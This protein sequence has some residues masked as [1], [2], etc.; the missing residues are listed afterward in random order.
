MGRDYGGWTEVE[1]F[2]SLPAGLI[3][4]LEAELGVETASLR[5]FEAPAGGRILL[6]TEDARRNLPASRL[7]LSSAQPLEGASLL[8]LAGIGDAAGHDRALASLLPE[9]TA[10]TRPV[11]VATERSLPE[12]G[13][14]ASAYEAERVGALH[15]GS[16]HG[17]C[18]VYRVARRAAAAVSPLA[19]KRPEHPDS[20]ARRGEW[21]S[22]RR[23]EPPE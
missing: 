12:S 15:A 6:L 2:S 23:G 19:E 9:T 14:L 11:L 13:E 21:F 17:S 5:R 7:D 4:E 1:R 10:A 18:S 22:R 16:E 8:V 3:A 20:V